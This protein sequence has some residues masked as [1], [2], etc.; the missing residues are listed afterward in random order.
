MNGGKVIWIRE[1]VKERIDKLRGSGQSRSGIINDLCAL[2][3]E[4]YPEKARKAA[5]NGQ[6]NN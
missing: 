5:S 6:S 4:V 1:D 2:W 3:E